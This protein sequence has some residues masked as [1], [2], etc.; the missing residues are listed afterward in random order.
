MCICAVVETAHPTASL[1]WREACVWLLSTVTSLER[2]K[3]PRSPQQSHWFVAAD[4]F[5]PSLPVGVT[6]RPPKNSCGYLPPAK[7]P[8]RKWDQAKQE[9]TKA[10]RERETSQSAG[11]LCAHKT[12]ALT[13]KTSDRQ[14]EG[15][16]NHLVRVIHSSPTRFNILLEG[17]KSSAECLRYRFLLGRDWVFLFQLKCFEP[18]LSNKLAGAAA[19]TADEAHLMSSSVSKVESHLRGFLLI[20]LSLVQH[21]MLM[22]EWWCRLFVEGIPAEKS[23]SWVLPQHFHLTDLRLLIC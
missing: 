17:V 7:V 2:Q 16:S 4:C 6:D 9:T 22:S 14:A 23:I 15:Q 20:W 3:S 11:F 5:S 21:F 1:C 19:G 13:Q 8:L 10:Q 18:P 12:T